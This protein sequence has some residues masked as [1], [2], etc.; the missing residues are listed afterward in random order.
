MCDDEK[1]FISQ[2]QVLSPCHFKNDYYRIIYYACTVHVCKNMQ[3]FFVDFSKIWVC[4]CKKTKKTDR[5]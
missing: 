4:Q 2:I 1:G 5:T 3:H